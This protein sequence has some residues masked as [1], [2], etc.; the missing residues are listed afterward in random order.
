MEEG[1]ALPGERDR[2]HDLEPTIV[3]AALS[4]CD[5]DE[6]KAFFRDGVG[7]EAGTALHHPDGERPWGLPSGRRRTSILSGGSVFL[8]LVHY[9]GSAARSRPSDEGFE[10]QGFRTVAVG[11]HDPAET[12][13]FFE[14]VKASG[15]NWATPDPASFVGGHY[16]VGAASHRLET[17]SVPVELERKFGYS[18]EPHKWWRPP[19]RAAPRSGS[20]GVDSLKAASRHD[21]YGRC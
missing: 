6:A 21:I 11:S 16:V 18:P 4:V 12:G 3:Y 20:S 8:E 2:Y 9:E 19:H 13:A 15:L 1:E 14:R 7:L 17:L 10:R 5:L